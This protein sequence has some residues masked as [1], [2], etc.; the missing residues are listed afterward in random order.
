M[1]SLSFIILI[2]FLSLATGCTNQ[3]SPD[4]DENQQLLVVDGMI[5]DQ[6]RVNRIKLSRSMPIGKPL[7]RN[8]VKGAVV[9]ITDEKG[10]V[11]TLKEFPAGTYSTDSLKFRGCVGGRYA[12]NIKINNV[13]YATD[14]TEMKPVP[15]IDSLYYEKVVLTA[16]NDIED[17]DEGCKIYLDSRDPSNNCLFFRWNYTETWEYLIPYTVTNRIC[18]VYGRSREVLIKNTSIFSQAMVTKYPVLF[19]SNNTDKLKVKYSIL[20]NQYSLNE[21]EFDFWDKVQ[22][23][24]ENVG[25]LYD[26]T[27]VAISGNI[28]C[29]TNPGET[30][31]GY[32]SVSAVSQKRLF[33]RDKFLGQP[34]FYTYCATDT[35]YGSLPEKELNKTYWVI[36]DNSNEIPPWWVITEYRECADCTTEGTKIRPP[37][38]DEDLF[39]K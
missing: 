10:T 37:F 3:F 21:S 19:I 13:Y 12:L 25:N 5:T 18:W 39:N 36:E 30:V 32:F 22:N 27:P 2:L 15:P 26:I 9:T 24:S 20:V 1:R 35:I 7:V 8:P 16:S 38:W 4:I 17:V 33:I 23:I 14:F 29:T 6:Y 34:N 31:H 28:R 11:S